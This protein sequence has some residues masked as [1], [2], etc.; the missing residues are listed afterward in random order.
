MASCPMIVAVNKRLETAGLTQLPLQEMKKIII[1]NKKS[2]HEEFY[3]ILKNRYCAKFIL[4]KIKLYY[5]LDFEDMFWQHH[6][7]LLL[8]KKARKF[9]LTA[10]IKVS[11]ADLLMMKEYILEPQQLVDYVES[12]TN[13]FDQIYTQ[14][15]KEIGQLVREERVDDVLA[16]N[17]DKPFELDDEHFKN[18]VKKTVVKIKQLEDE[19]A[20]SVANSLLDIYTMEQYLMK[21]VDFR[22]KEKYFENFNN[23]LTNRELRELVEIK[24]DLLG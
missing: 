8:F 19:N 10:K 20:I 2:E 22:D 7:A 24:L 15:L 13:E 5:L 17:I 23:R 12:E 11:Y 21:L 3:E 9:M 16:E 1:N 6:M 4:D 14:F 18:M